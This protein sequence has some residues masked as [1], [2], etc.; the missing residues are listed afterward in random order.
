[1]FYCSL[2]PSTS[3]NLSVSLDQVL[4]NQT[5]RVQESDTEEQNSENENV[6]RDLQRENKIPTLNLSKVVQTS[7][8]PLIK[9]HTKVETPQKVRTSMT[10]PNRHYNNSAVYTFVVNPETPTSSIG[11]RSLIDLSTPGRYQTPQTKQ[12]SSLLK[13]TIKKRALLTPR[14]TLLSSAR[15]AMNAGDGKSPLDKN[16]S[17]PLVKRLGTNTPKARFSLN[18]RD[19]TPIRKFGLNS[20]LT[21]R[22]QSPAMRMSM[23]G[24]SSLNDTKTPIGS[25][26]KICK[27]PT[28]YSISHLKLDT[29][30]TI[31]CK[32]LFATL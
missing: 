13:S 20:P 30:K 18:E 23:S 8:S 3:E 1:M 11:S 27:T 12:S 21:K 17:S 7:Y 32:Y 14:S 15:L 25:A 16:T 2:G 9:Y 10:T 22:V 6:K 31:K 19:L 5:L 26:K 4:L 29:S 24:I 28:K